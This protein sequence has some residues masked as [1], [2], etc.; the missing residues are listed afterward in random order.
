MRKDKQIAE[1]LRRTGK[2]YKYIQKKLGIPISTLSDW[3]RHES[4]SAKI[5]DRLAFTE[6]LAYPEKLKKLQEI[7][8][9]KY[10]QLHNAYREEAILEFQN[11]KGNPTFISG[12]MLYW[13][14]GDKNV[15]NCIV[16][17]TNSEPSMIRVFYA[18]LV[19]VMRVPKEKIKLHL[20]LYPD[21]ID[22]LQ[23]KIWSKATGISQL[24]F[25]KSVFIKGKHA[26]RRLSHGV[27]MITVCG[28]KY[29]EKI[30]KWI[31]LHANEIGNQVVA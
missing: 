1:K 16:R 20:L 10:D 27:G 4:W 18:F 28:R 11:L 31:E 26:K 5:R 24:Q 7:V 15:T 21:L 3:F 2:S 13:G 19:N 8:R 12:I 14:E 17:L 29:K 6:S 23:K 25:N 30:L 22:S 9:K